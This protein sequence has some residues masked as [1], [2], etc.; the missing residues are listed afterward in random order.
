VLVNVSSIRLMVGFAL[1]FNAT[2]W[3]QQLGFFSSFAIFAGALGGVSLALPLIYF[4]GKRI[5]RWTAGQLEAS[6]K[7]MD[8]EAKGIA[9]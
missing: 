6:L 5:R 3:V 8:D 1:S 9:L 4:Y 7:I 2:S